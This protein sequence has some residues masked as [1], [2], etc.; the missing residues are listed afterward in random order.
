MNKY[1]FVVISCLVLSCTNSGGGSGDGKKKKDPCESPNA[2][3][4][5]ESN[6]PPTPRLENNYGREYFEQFLFKKEDVSDD[7]DF[8]EYI[9]RY[10]MSGLQIDF[11]NA[12]GEKM[13]A[14]LQ[15]GLFEDGT[16]RAVYDEIKYLDD[17]GGFFPAGCKEITGTWDVPNDELELFH[18]GKNVFV[19]S[20]HFEEN[21]HRV[22]TTLVSPILS[23]E[24]IK[25]SFSLS[26]GYT[27]V[28]YPEEYLLK[29]ANFPFPIP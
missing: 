15:I 5:E 23:N 2:C 12:A 7:P 24:A 6:T 21:E 8:P 18:E 25:L 26:L 17:N 19:G 9:Y 16:F 13:G 1:I 4:E 11:V 3:I 29:C 22:L 27:N 10:L 20:K 14:K 28:G